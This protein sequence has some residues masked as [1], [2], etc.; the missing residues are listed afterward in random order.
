VLKF[1]NA[2]TGL[3]L[4]RLAV[5]I[6][7]LYH[8]WIKL[9]SIDQTIGFFASIGLSAFWAYLAALIETLGGIA[10][11][12]GIFTRYVAVLLA[13]DALIAIFKIHLGN[14]FSIVDGGYEYVFVLLFVSIAIFVS[15]AGKYSAAKWIKKW[16]DA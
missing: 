3:L 1:H 13:A 5:G 8:G 2:D 9:T 15:G 10:F 4:L 14:G 7:F 16:E 12:L 6:V 11:I